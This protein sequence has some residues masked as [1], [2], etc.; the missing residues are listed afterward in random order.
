MSLKI[1]RIAIAILLFITPSSCMEQYSTDDEILSDDPFPDYS[2]DIFNYEVNLDIDESRFYE[3]ST[4]QSFCIPDLLNVI[5]QIEQQPELK[6]AKKEKSSKTQFKQLTKNKSKKRTECPIC[7]SK[8]TY[9]NALI[10]HIKKR[11]ASKAN[12]ICYSCFLAFPDQIALKG[13][14]NFEHT[15]K[16]KRQFICGIDGCTYLYFKDSTH[17][18]HIEYKHSKLEIACDE[19]GCYYKCTNI[20]ALKQHKKWRHS[21]IIACDECSYRGPEIGLKQH[22]QRHHIDQIFS[23]DEDLCEF[24]TT[25]IHYLHRHIIVVHGDQ[26]S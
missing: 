9:R 13:H 5:P 16:S 4:A 25:D 21:P 20:A 1:K 7:P 14:Y 24:Q 8:Y 23:C 6:I 26:N 3:K 10:T 2:E 11:H 15:K 22:K 17:R 18:K 12:L 19:E